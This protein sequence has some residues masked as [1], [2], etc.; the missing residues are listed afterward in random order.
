MQP[1]L[2]VIISSPSGGGKDA[3]INA[4]L[5][6][7]PNSARFVTTT[8]RPPRPGNQEGVDYHFITP[9]EFVSKIEKGNFI[10][11]NFYAGHY[12][13][14]EKSRLDEALQKYQVVLT[15]IEVNGKHNMDKAGIPHLAIFLLP[16][17]LE[18]LKNRI[19]QRGGVSPANLQERL[20]IAEK[21]IAASGD[22]DYRI[23][24]AEGKLE[25]TIEKISAII[26]EKLSQRHTLDEK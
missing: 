13:G 22:Y 12:Y 6:M 16:E 23:V 8:S 2:L 14:T 26:K 9:E 21:E 19:V 5:K 4:L 18:V 20:N 24:N 11:Y 1:G 17:S 10:E 7:F 25:E 15:Q 3:V